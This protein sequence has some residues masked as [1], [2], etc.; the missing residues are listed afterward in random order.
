MRMLKAA[1]ADSGL[2][3]HDMLK[4]YIDYQNHKGT[5]SFAVIALAKDQ[6]AHLWWQQWGK[7]TP[8]LQFVATRAL[9]QCVAASC[10]EQ[11]WSEYDLIHCRRRNRL[12]KVYA[13]NLTCGHNQTRLIRQLNK[14]TYTEKF[15]NWTDSDDDE[16]EAFFSD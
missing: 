14:V 2:N 12:G 10:S 13:S 3:I 4:E 9:A 1:H 11:G 6:P 5:F 8:S 7:A 15:L 16:E